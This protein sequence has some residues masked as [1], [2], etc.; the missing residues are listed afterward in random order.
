MRQLFLCILS[1]SLSGAFTGLVLLLIRPLTGKFFSKK[2]NYYIWLLLVVR[3]LIPVYF[4]IPGG[5]W[6]GGSGLTA[7]AAERQ[8]KMLASTVPGHGEEMEEFPS[9]YSVEEP[10]SPVMPEPVAPA[11]ISGLQKSGRSLNFPEPVT[12][13]AAIWLAGA[14]FCFI[15]KMTGYIRFNLRIQKG[16]KEVSDEQLLFQMA[17][18]CNRLHIKKQPVLRESLSVSGPITV[19][20]FKPAVILPADDFNGGSAEGDS[21][22]HQILVLHHELIHIRR[23]DLWYKWLYQLLLCIHWFNPV[24]Y[25]VAGKLNRDCELSCDEEVLGILTRD[26]KRAY[27]NLLINAAEHSL[28]VRSS[29]LFSTTLLERK[30]DLKERLQGILQYKKQERG[31]I[32]ISLCAALG[33]LFLSACGS[34]QAEPD[35]MPVRLSAGGAMEDAAGAYASDDVEK[36]SEEGFSW[37]SFWGSLTERLF[38]YDVDDFLDNRM[39]V[40]K[41][42]KAWKAYDDDELLA[43]KDI[44][45]QRSAFVYS[46]GGNKVSCSGLLLNGTE[47]VRIVNVEEEAELQIDSSFELIEGRFKVIYVDPEGQVDVLNETGES[48]SCIVTLKKGRNVIKMAGQGA[49]LKKLEIRYSDPEAGSVQRVYYSETEEYADLIQKEIEEGKVDKKELF[50]ALPYMEEEKVS[51]ALGLLLEN[52]IPLDTDEV[53]E[54]LV[55][56]DIEQS[57]QYLVNAVR[58]GKYKFADEEALSHIILYL[59]EKEAGELLMALMDGEEGFDF[60][61]LKDN[62]L[63]L[64]EGEQEKCMLH[65]FEQG[66]SLTYSQFA[67]ISPY[68]SKRA[69]EK[70]DEKM[71]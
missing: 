22:G 25:F 51:Q 68:L 24:L 34:V 67:E 18:L 27:G 3:L 19:G 35:A 55:Y 39:I 8:G 40:N 28:S 13:F 52:G 26:G 60:K 9:Q 30:R 46:G 2:W 29:N 1:L 21:P 31:R 69:I 15:R 5:L 45:G 57:G 61:L 17:D 23:R 37:V 59:D 44:S 43:G 58:N 16:S 14:C 62:I 20:L 7:E 11:G 42:G 6:Q 70:I 49:K 54:L 56:S 10:D 53:Y 4:E 64:G 65:Y 36:N 41:N 38:D 50:N 12:L 66:Y 33:L 71:K 47:S 63:Y 32:A 48:S